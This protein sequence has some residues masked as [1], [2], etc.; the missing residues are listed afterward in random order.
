MTGLTR[1][2]LLNLI[3]PTCATTNCRKGDSSA[4]CNACDAVLKVLL[5]RY[6]STLISDTLDEFREKITS[7][8]AESSDFADFVVTDHIIDKVI[9]EMKGEI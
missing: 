2:G 4:S 6:D 9:R 3:C 7:Y 5:D 1:E 8:L